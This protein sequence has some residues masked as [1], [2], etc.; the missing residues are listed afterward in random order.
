MFAAIAL[1]VLLIL[2][3]SSVLGESTKEKYETVQ[4]EI[5]KQEEKLRQ[6]KEKEHSIVEELGDLNREFGQISREVDLQKKKIQDTQGAVERLRG[7]MTRV[8]SA[9]SVQRENLNRRLRSM[10]RYG[11]GVDRLIVLLN[12]DDFFRAVRI[13]RYL[14]RISE[15]EYDQIERYKG[16]VSELSGKE[17][18]MRSLLALLKEKNLE[19][20]RA[21][22]KLAQKKKERETLLSSVKKEQTLYSSMLKELE[23]TSRR[24]KELLE[25]TEPE[26]AYA[27]KGF[28][29]LKGELFW[30]VVGRLAIPYG[31]NKDPRFDTPVFRNGIYVSTEPDTAVRS[32]CEGR[33]VFADWFKGLG[34]VVIINHGSGYHTV[35][36]NLSSISAKVGDIIR[37]KVII[38]NAGDNGVLD[39]PGIYFEI[40]YK[41]KPINPLH[42][43]RKS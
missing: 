19:L 30:P 29:K 25:K 27:G 22:E 28:Q 17:K 12:S 14:A 20:A 13:S 10:Q 23:G 43:L 11:G 24:L 33:V 42:W 5:K 1:T 8:G 37:E 2:L 35:Y 40:R 26:Q 41:G 36:A 18:K 38:G 4:E 39:G 34:Q 31:S 3:P 9:L 32:V 21:E 6:A 15:Y 16:T 7:E